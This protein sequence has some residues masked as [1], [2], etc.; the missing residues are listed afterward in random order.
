MAT[1]DIHLK[2]PHGITIVNT[3][4]EVFVREDGQLLGR[5]RISRGS[6]DWLPSKKQRPRRLRWGR[7]A[8]LMDEYGTPVKPK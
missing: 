7:F 8:E 5:I 4:V 3:D 1:H 2:I 6:I